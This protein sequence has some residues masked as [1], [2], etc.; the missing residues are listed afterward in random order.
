LARIVADH[1]TVAAR[2]VDVVM[3]GSGEVERR[4]TVGRAYLD[5]SAR[6]V[7]A[8][9]LIAKFRLVAVKRDKLVAPKGLNLVLRGYTR[10]LSPLS[11]VASHRSNLLVASGM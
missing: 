9:K 5:N 10:F 7:C 2:G 4:N 6:I 8:A 1:D 11:V 3:H